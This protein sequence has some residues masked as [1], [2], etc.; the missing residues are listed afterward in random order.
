MVRRAAAEL[1]VDPSRSV[2]IGDHGSDAAVAAHFPGMRGVLILT[3]HG[4]GQW[5]KIQ[6]GE[7]P[8]PE[9]VA[10]DLLAAVRW[11]LDGR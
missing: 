6:A 5:E 10:A 9:H 4:A 11:L 3:G 7:I 1:G 8:M 2:I